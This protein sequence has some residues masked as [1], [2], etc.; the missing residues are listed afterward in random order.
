MSEASEIDDLRA[1]LSDAIKAR[2]EA[3]NRAKLKD[4]SAAQL[5]VELGKLK[6]LNVECNGQRVNWETQAKAAAQEVER[7]RS[8][9][10]EPD[11]VELEDLRTFVRML[12]PVLGMTEGKHKLAEVLEHA[13]KAVKVSRFEQL[14][15]DAIEKLRE[16]LDPKHRYQN[17][18]VVELA[19]TRVRESE[20]V[21]RDLVA[22]E[23]NLLGQLSKLQHEVNAGRS[24]GSSS[25]EE[26]ARRLRMAKGFV[27]ILSA[28]LEDMSCTSD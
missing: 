13:R 27:E 4:D 21:V 3:E 2:D 14:T 9:P 10:K 25:Q 26:A 15:D 20:E 18:G 5:A 28:L 1:K 24:G 11:Q 8:L 6:K 12:M 22:R 7:L 16:I 17:L 19:E 23:E